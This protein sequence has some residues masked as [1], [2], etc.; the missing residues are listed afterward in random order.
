MPLKKCP[1]CGEALPKATRRPNPYN[2]YVK[3]KMQLPQIKALPT[4]KRM[5]AVAKLW[6]LEKEVKAKQK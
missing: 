5:G 2:L 1:N 3:E 6:R 4:T